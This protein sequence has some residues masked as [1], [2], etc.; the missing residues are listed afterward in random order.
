MQYKN[1]QLT[2]EKTFSFDGM[3]DST[4]DGSKEL[5]AG[6]CTDYF[7]SGYHKAWHIID[8]NGTKHRMDTTFDTLK[9]IDGQPV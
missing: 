7:R 1:H 4:I 6:L 9:A 5:I 2:F 8:K 3:N